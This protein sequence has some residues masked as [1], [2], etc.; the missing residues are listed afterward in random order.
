[1]KSEAVRES[2]FAMPHHSPSYPRGPYRYSGCDYLTITYRST[3]EAVRRVV[4][5]PLTVN[6][7]LVN[8]EFVHM[9]DSTGFGAY[10]GAAQVI[11]VRF[12]SR[13]GRWDISIARFH[14]RKSP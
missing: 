14:R 12:A 5:E 4:P 8:I 10:S 7:P 1:M 11:P 13:R 6:E 9:P 3:D 2:A